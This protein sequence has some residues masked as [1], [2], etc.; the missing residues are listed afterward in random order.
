[1]FNEFFTPLLIVALSELGDKTQFAIFALSS[2]HHHDKALISGIV[3]GFFITTLLAVFFGS[4]ISSIIPHQSLKLISST[5]FLFFGFALIFH[6]P[7][8]RMNIKKFRHFF[9][10]SFTLVLVT[11][12]GDKSQI[13]TSLFSA[14]A[15]QILVFIGALSGLIIV[16]LGTIY[17]GRLIAKNLNQKITS[18]ISGGIFILVGLIYLFNFLFY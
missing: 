12:L 11:E 6:K 2:K 14:G 1:M 5:I 13:V 9:T 3:L 17:L 10:A 16:S 18:Y 7:E 15:N 8:Q 4:I